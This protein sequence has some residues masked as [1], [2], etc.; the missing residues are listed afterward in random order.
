MQHRITRWMVMPRVTL[1]AITR[2]E[3]W[4]SVKGKSGQAQHTRQPF[5][6]FCSFLSLAK[7]SLL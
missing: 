4:A 3:K 1:A 5:I 7:C 2:A 6:I